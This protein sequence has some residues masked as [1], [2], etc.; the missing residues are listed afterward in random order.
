MFI[1]YLHRTER[2][3]SFLLRPEVTEEIL[4][5]LKN[6]KPTTDKDQF[7]N[8][9]KIRHELVFEKIQK[10]VIIVSSCVAVS[11]LVIKLI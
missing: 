4:N 8:L 10:P 1:N 3:G 11:L 2:K 5:Y 9:E 7:Y 6:H